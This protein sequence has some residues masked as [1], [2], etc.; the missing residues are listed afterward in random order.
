MDKKPTI[1]EVRCVDTRENDKIKNEISE[2]KVEVIAIEDK[3][4]EN[5]LR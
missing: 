3:M 4:R 2:V 1:S 5:W